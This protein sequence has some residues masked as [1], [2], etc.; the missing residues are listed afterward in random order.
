MAKNLVE[1]Y[2]NRLAIS[3]SVYQKSHNGARMSSQKK[4][5][6]AAVLDNTARF[7]NE[8][9]DSTAATQR[10]ALGDYKKFALNVTTVALPNLIL[11]ELMLT[12]PMSSL[13]GYV[14]YLRYQAGTDKGGVSVDQT[15]NGVYGL[16]KMDEFRAN[17]TSSFVVEPV[18]AED[19][20]CV[21]AWTPVEGTV[22]GIAA[23]GTKT[24]LTPSNGKV[25]FTA[26]T[27]VKVAYQYNNE[28][29]P[30]ASEPNSLPTLKAKLASINLHAHA[31]RI[32]VYYSQIAA[33]Q[34]KNDYGFDLGQQLAAQAQGELA[35]EID[36]EG[37]LMLSKGAEHDTS[38]DI[39][40]FDDYQTSSVNG[41]YISRSQYYE[42]ISEKVAK[43]KAIIYNR[44]QKFAPNYMVCGSNV[45]TVLPY[46]KGWVAAPAANV[47]GPYFAGTLD[48][49][50]VFVSPAIDPNEFFF[51]VNGSDLQTS[52]AIYAPYMAIVP[53]QL[54]GFADGNM[55]QGFS[56]MYDMKLLSTYNGTAANP[57]EVADGDVGEFSWLLVKGALV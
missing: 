14:T 29:I 30:Q 5:M 26:G 53:T 39:K 1:S 20:E 37:V 8:A 21:L 46:V 33:F 49:L 55:S 48:S 54:L 50:K 9:M 16:G 3:E 51:G 57:V 17:Y 19:V 42:V 40:S 23:N 44:T 7:L 28:I 43:A 25:T 13:A 10:T 36:T 52:A 38:L 4:L 56:T 31:R 27:Y 22:Y 24:P 45:L 41:T 35:Y 18:G 47:N 34:A 11:P 12:Q 32:A 2:K 6:I 15:F